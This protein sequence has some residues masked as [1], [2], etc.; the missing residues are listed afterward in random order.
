VSDYG[1]HTVQ[2]RRISYCQY[3]MD[4][5]PDTAA[6]SKYYNCDSIQ[7]SGAFTV[8]SSRGYNLSCVLH[9]NNP[10]CNKIVVVCHG[11]FCN[12]ENRLVRVLCERIPINCVRFD[13]HG[14]GDSGGFDEW[15]FGGYNGD[16]THDLRPLV[17]LLRLRN[18]EV[19]ALIGHS[20]GGNEVL[21][22]SMKY[23]DVPLIFVATPFLKGQWISRR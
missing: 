10:E 22:Y 11:L 17:T 9:R 2:R 23:D 18:Y 5:L 21:M 14:N 7:N 15:S 19:V 3:S 6:P 16:V 1:R 13:F 4:M 12:K 8:V 20:R